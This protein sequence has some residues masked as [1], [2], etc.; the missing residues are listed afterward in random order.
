MPAEPSWYLMVGEDGGIS[1][2]ATSPP[3]ITRRHPPTR[4][5]VAVALMR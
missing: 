4:P 5:V 2:S 3:G 1:R